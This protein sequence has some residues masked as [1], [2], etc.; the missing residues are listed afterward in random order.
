MLVSHPKEVVFARRP[1][2]FLFR[3]RLDSMMKSWRDT[4]FIHG[5]AVA[6]FLIAALAA[7]VILTALMALLNT[8]P[9]ESLTQ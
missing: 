5:N 7:V 4:L 9:L 8:L 3:M 1:P 2:D 6:Q